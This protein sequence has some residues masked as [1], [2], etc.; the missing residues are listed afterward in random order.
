[1]NVNFT[2]LGL[3]CFLVMTGLSSSAAMA[4][5]ESLFIPVQPC[6]LLDT[7]QVGG[8]FGN[9]ETRP[10]DVWGADLSNQGGAAFDCGVSSSAVAVHVTLHAVGPSD[11]GF[12]RAWPYGAGE[13]NATLLNYAAG[14]SISNSTALAICNSSVASCLFDIE[15]KIYYGVTDFVIDVLGYYEPLAP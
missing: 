7:R 9:G 15:V 8:A 6:R 12:V 2:I 11:Y 13:P 1:M 5:N 14:Q 4:Q 3:I 10:Y